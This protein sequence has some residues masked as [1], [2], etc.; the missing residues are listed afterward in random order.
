MFCAKLMSLFVLSIYFCIICGPKAIIAH[1]L[2]ANTNKL[3]SK[4]LSDVSSKVSN[5]DIPLTDLS[6]DSS[7]NFTIANATDAAKGIVIL[8]II[9]CAFTIT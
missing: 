8:D 3:S 4:V 2:E 1:P 9:S 6:Y 7:P 5:N